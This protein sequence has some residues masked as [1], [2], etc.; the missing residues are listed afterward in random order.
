MVC[1][2]CKMNE[3]KNG[4]LTGYVLEEEFYLELMVRVTQ[5]RV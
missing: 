3:T 1:G 4:L 5:V 2:S